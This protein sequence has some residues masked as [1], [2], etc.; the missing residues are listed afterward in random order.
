MCG[1]KQAAAVP[2]QLETSASE[3]LGGDDGGVLYLV[4][5]ASERRWRGAEGFARPAQLCD[6]EPG[7]AGLSG[8]E[9]K[10]CVSALG[11]SNRAADG[12]WLAETVVPSG[13]GSCAR[14]NR[15]SEEEPD[16]PDRNNKNVSKHAAAECKQN[17]T[18]QQ[19]E[20]AD[21]KLDWKLH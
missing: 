9:D 11:H 17:M 10:P 19:I 7:R 3:R 12:C 6:T 18:I 5:R 4:G 16:A 21:E 14:S 13:E 8:Y 20:A 1:G 15:L 2:V